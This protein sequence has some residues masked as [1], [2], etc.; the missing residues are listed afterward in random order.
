MSSDRLKAPLRRALRARGILPGRA[1]AVRLTVLTGLLM[2]A[3]VDPLVE[4]PGARGG[5]PDPGVPLGEL[6]G[7]PAGPSPL[8]PGP[9]SPEPIVPGDPASPSSTTTIAT[10]SPSVSPS[11]TVDSPAP[12]ATADIPPEVVEL[13]EPDAPAD[14]GADAGSLRLH[15]D[16]DSETAPH[17]A[18]G[19]DAGSNGVS[20]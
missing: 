16:L 15:H 14:A 5:Q 3:C 17:P 12:G 18:L 4:D 8:S 20:K 11:V 19:V 6:P 10:G 7:N 1:Y 2:P 9:L 13:E